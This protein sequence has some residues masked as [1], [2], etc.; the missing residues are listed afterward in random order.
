M[1]ALALLSGTTARA[2]AAIILLYGFSQLLRLLFLSVSVPEQA[3]S[4]TLDSADFHR[5]VCRPEHH[6]LKSSRGTRT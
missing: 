1:R 6:I 4:R 3:T 5:H 2:T